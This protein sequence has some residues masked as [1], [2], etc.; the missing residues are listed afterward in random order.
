MLRKL[1]IALAVLMVA[2]LIAALLLPRFIDSKQLIA[3]LLTKI[4]RDSGV[5]VEVRGETRLALLP[6]PGV[7]LGDISVQLPDEETPGIRAREFRLGMQLMPLLSRRVEVDHF[8]LE[9]LAYTAVTKPGEAPPEL[10]LRG[11]FSFDQAAGQLHLEDVEATLRGV[12][13]EPVELRLA[14]PV[15]VQAQSA[16][17]QLALDSGDARGEGTLRY[18]A[19]SSPEIDAALHLN[20]FTPALFALAGPE[21]AAEAGTANSVDGGPALPIDALRAM[22]LRADLRIDEVVWEGHLVRDF[23]ARLRVNNGSAILP[24]VS[25][26]V[27]GGKLRMKANINAREANPRVNTSGKLA[28]VDIAK[29]LEAAEVEAVMTGRASLDWELHGAG[30]TAD[31]IRD[32]LR[33]PINLTTE[34]AVLTAVGVEKELCDVVSTINRESMVTTLPDSSRFEQL[35]ATIQVRGGKAH[36]QPLKARLPQIGLT[37]KGELAL[38]SQQFTA[39]FNARLSPELEQLDPA[40]RVNERLTAIKWPVVCA[41]ELSGEPRDWCSVDS[42]EILKDL[43]ENE[44]KRKASEGLDKHLGEGAGDALK[45]L[46]GD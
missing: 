22:D 14:G 12:L 43:G 35:T 17:L 7:T 37:G 9:N 39:Q 30:L 36:L 42:A 27:H 4:E 15:D 28:S 33:G 19:N 41:G 11:G 31:A 44:L 6:R 45:K 29:L 38:A 18:T 2:L 26:K 16:D 21:A 24:E 1:L 34:D 13:P 46:F 25:G 23:K 32:S 5:R 10:D 20:R 8:A 40:C 3:P